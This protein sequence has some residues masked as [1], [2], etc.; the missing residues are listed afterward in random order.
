MLVVR[1][2][3]GV[4]ELR[5]DGTWGKANRPVSTDGRPAPSRAVA[6]ISRGAMATNLMKAPSQL[7]GK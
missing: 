3:V 1:V 4:E 5:F 2:L 7:L 6:S